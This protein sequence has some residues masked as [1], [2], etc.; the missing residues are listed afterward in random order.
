MRERSCKLVVAGDADSTH[1]FNLRKN[2]A[3]LMLIGLVADSSL[4]S[5]VYDQLDML[6]VPSVSYDNVRYVL[7]KD[8]LQ[9]PWFSTRQ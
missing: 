5:K 2:T 9:G 6:V 3:I 1:A 7:W 4:L 8:A